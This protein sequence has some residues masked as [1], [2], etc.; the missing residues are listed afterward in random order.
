MNAAAHGVTVMAGAG[1]EGPTGPSSIT[2]QGSITSFFLHRTGEWPSD[3]PLVTAV[4]GTQLH[5]TDSG[6]RTQ[7]D[8]VWNDTSLLNSLAAGGGG[9]STVFSRPSYQNDVSRVVGSQ[10]GFPDLALS[11]AF[12]GSALVFM[13]NVLSQALGAPSASFFLVGGTSLASPLFS[14]VVA[15]ADQK[16]GH[17]LG[18]INPALYEMQESGA[19]G[20]VDITAGTNTVTFTQNGAVH[21]VLGWDA[22]KGYDLASGVGTVD[23]AKFVP[24]LVAAAG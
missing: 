6:A 1:D 2:S 18:L 22:V 3:D 21:T 20:I 5:L 10:R 17:G 13:D 24:E 7:P 15:I 11:A 9:H 14:G 4:G 23:G 16:A 12:D 8:N 19:P